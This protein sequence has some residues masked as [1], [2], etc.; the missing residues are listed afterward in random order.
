MRLQQAAAW[1]I[2]RVH[3]FRCQPRFWVGCVEL[4][5]GVTVAAEGATTAVLLM[6]RQKKGNTEHRLSKQF[7]PS[8]ENHVCDTQAAVM[9]LLKVARGPSGER[10]PYSIAVLSMSSV[11]VRD[12]NPQRNRRD[13]WGILQHNNITVITSPLP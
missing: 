12:A 5:K 2:R 4:L 8:S 10:P 1:F 13:N 11:K 9:V 6:R 7:G 3:P